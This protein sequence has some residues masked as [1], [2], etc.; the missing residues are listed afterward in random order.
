MM[1]DLALLAILTE[2]LQVVPALS[3]F[4]YT[5]SNTINRLARIVSFHSITYLSYKQTLLYK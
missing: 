1:A 3:R 2:S 5:Y 4:Q